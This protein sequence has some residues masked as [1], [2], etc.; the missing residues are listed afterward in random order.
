[1]GTPTQVTV[2]YRDGKL[3]DRTEQ[4]QAEIEA[5]R[6]RAE[7]AHLSRVALKNRPH[8]Q[9]MYGVWNPSGVAG[10][11]G[12]SLDD[13]VA[14]RLIG[15][16]MV[17][18]HHV[19]SWNRLRSPRRPRRALRVT[20]SSSALTRSRFSILIFLTPSPV[21]KPHRGNRVVTTANRLH[22]HRC[23]DFTG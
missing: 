19:P 5:R 17:L 15:R 4:R 2:E 20:E 16:A 10:L 7:V 1:M 12:V 21:R 13:Q 9:T 3:R 23:R 14:H 6:T 8:A 11:L 22:D 18:G